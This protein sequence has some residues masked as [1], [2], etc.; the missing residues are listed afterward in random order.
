M[1][2]VHLAFEPD[3]AAD[4]RRRRK[5]EQIE[6]ILARAAWLPDSDRAVLEAV[7]GEG[8]T[9]TEVAVLMG[10]PPRALRRRVRRLLDRVLAHRFVFVTSRIDGW[11]PTR[12]R[13]ATACVIEG[14]SL[15]DAA[16]RLGIS[17]YSVRRHHEAINAQLEAVLA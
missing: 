13:V 4:L 16:K 6:Q 1:S 14:C 5:R 7:F 2:N 15:R 12:R 10:C 8:K 11:P 17:L 3:E 9:V